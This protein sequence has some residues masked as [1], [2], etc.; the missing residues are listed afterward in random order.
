MKKY[1]TIVATGLFVLALAVVIL[2]DVDP[3]IIKPWGVFHIGMLTIYMIVGTVLVT[4][5]FQKIL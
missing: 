3:K 1:W 2:V 4:I 5:G